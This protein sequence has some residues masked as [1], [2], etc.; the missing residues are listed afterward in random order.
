MKRALVLCPGRGSYGRDN[1]GSLTGLVSTRLD[2][3]EQHR[4]LAGRPTPREMDAAEKFSSKFHI[5]GENASSLTAAVT[6]ADLDQIDGSRFELVGV[7]GNSMGWYTAL[8]YAGALSMED[9]A[10]LIETLGQYQ[11]GNII[12]GQ[13]VYPMVDEQWRIDPE[14][15]ATVEGIVAS[16]EGLHW[17]IRLGG[18]AVLGGT[19]AALNAAIDQLPSIELGAHTFPLRLPLHSAFHTPLMSDTAVRAQEELSRLAWQAPSTT[20]IDGNGQVWRPVYSDPIALR[21]YTLG[22]QVVAPFNL[23]RCIHTALRTVAPDVIILPGPGSNLGSAIAQT[24]IAERWNGID[25]RDAFIERQNSDPI[26]LSM[27]W[28]DQRAR[29]VTP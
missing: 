25:S 14:R 17:S 21:D 29:V 16:I 10:Q 24:L 2:V 3:F 5:R 22:A 18:Q 20:M 1:L 27:R 4:T 23:K 6:V 11:A 9:C 8:G 7:I 19:E 28:P 26:L 15:Q 13:I 12:G